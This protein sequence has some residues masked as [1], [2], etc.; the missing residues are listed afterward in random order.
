MAVVLSHRQDNDPFSPVHASSALFTAIS[1]IA[2]HLHNFSLCVNKISGPIT[3]PLNYE[4]LMKPE[5]CA[6]RRQTVRQR[7]AWSGHETISGVKRGY[8]SDVD[9]SKTQLEVL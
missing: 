4:Y 1:C 7:R 2:L 8:I 9:N 3:Y 6:E 5:D